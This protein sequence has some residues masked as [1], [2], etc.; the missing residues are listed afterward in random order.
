[1]ASASRDK[2]VV[3]WSMHTGTVLGVLGGHLDQVKMV[4]F[5]PDG[6][7]V[8]SAS[9]DHCI[10]VWDAAAYALVYMLRGH[11]A[12]AMSVGFHPDG[13]K[14]LSSS[15]DTTVAIWDIGKGSAGSTFGEPLE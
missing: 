6:K 2:T 14:L 4:K 1:M 15:D 7:M 11:T 10:G 9:D 13:S 3:V 12:A 5:S 8:A